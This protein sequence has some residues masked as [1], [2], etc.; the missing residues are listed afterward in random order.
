[1]ARDLYIVPKGLH[2]HHGSKFSNFHAM[3]IGDGDYDIVSVLFTHDTSRD[4]WENVPGVQ[5]IG[6][7][8]DSNPVSPAVISKLS[9]FGITEKHT[10]KD[11]RKIVKAA[12]KHPLF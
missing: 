3:P 10:A 7:E 4:E 2:M 12:S 9:E 5:V 6:N 11:V 8:Y 1:M